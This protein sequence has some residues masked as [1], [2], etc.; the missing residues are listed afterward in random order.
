MTISVGADGVSDFVSSVS[1]GTGSG[2]SPPSLD[3]PVSADCNAD[4]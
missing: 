2:A 4:S 3:R 1:S